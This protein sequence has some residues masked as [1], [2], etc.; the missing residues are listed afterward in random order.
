MESLQI[1][2]CCNVIEIRKK[3]LIY[4]FYVPV[5]GGIKNVEDLVSV[6][7]I[8]IFKKTGISLGSRMASFF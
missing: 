7:I 2:F 4:C 5:Y 3:N 6:L 8:Y 1:K